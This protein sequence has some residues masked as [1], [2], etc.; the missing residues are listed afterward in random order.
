MKRSRN[1]LA[2]EL[3]RWQLSLSIIMQLVCLYK[4]T[5]YLEFFSKALRGTRKIYL[6][7]YPTNQL[8]RKIITCKLAQ[9]KPVFLQK[10][11]NS[12]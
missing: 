11:C 12:Q 8:N 1:H 3:V 7:F 2:Y 10:G 4:H 9:E 6:L 5:G